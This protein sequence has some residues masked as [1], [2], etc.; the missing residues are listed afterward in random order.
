MLASLA[1]FVVV[2]AL[3]AFEIL[4]KVTA[5]LLGAVVVLALHLVPYE[6]AIAAID[7]NVIF[8]LIGM[9]IVMSIVSETGALE[10]LAVQIAQRA[11]GSA[12]R[13]VLQFLAVT[14]TLSAV[15]D[16]V[17][18]VILIAPITILITQLLE[19]PTAPVLI[20]MAIFSNIGGTATLIGDPPNI[21][22][23]SAGGLSFND[24]IVH[25]TP[26]VVGLAAT[27]L[28]LVRFQ[29]GPRL[30]EPESARQRLMLAEPRLAI[31]DAVRLRRSLLVLGV[32][33]LGF[34]TGR[35]IGLEPGVVALGGATLML[36]VCRV[37]VH[38]ALHKVEWSTLLFFIGLFMLVSALEHNEVF[39]LAGRAL[40]DWTSG[41]LLAT[42]I[43]ILWASAIASAIVD[44]I[45]L[46]IAMIPLI[47]SMIP[48]LAAQAGL[49]PSAD[50]VA[51]TI[52]EPLYWCLALGACLG[53]NGTL[54]GAS[55]N[56]VIAQ[57]ASRNGSP[58]SFWEFTRTGA[59][60][61]LITISL[62]TVYVVLRYF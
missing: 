34:F 29:L 39:T 1:V 47:K 54:I 45:P 36:V 9:M 5:A 10:W 18:T 60:F 58:I 50:V 52:A 30:S 7:M 56:V 14:A 37:D 3:I 48:A 53:G 43:A 25:L 51:A 11:R 13:I 57:I 16:N 15:L 62:S 38:E 22:I 35:V 19:V 4:D 2:Y 28:L 40:V 31:L 20:L 44:N 6:E 33:L 23:G 17:T 41:N 8:L 46:V 61:M 21:V 49:D 24:F 59:V 26:I 12:V 32:I 27:G 42:G 55:A